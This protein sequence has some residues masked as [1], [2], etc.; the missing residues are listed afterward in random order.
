MSRQITM[1]LGKRDSI[2][3]ITP[4]RT[5]LP[6]ATL[7]RLVLY[8]DRTGELVISKTTPIGGGYGRSLRAAVLGLPYKCARRV[9]GAINSFHYNDFMDPSGDR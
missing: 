8:R 7:K 9:F 5:A 2:T 3:I 4:D 1:K 6:I